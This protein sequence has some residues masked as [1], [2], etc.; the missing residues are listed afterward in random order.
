M[1]VVVINGSATAGKN[2]VVEMAGE[3]ADT[4]V[5]EISTIDKVIEAAN[6]L[7]Y[8]GI[9]DNKSRKFLSDLKDLATEYSNHSFNYV[10]DRVYRLRSKLKSEDRDSCVFFVHVREPDEIDKLKAHYKGKCVTLLIDRPFDSIPDNHADQD[11]KNYNYDYIIKNHFSPEEKGNKKAMKRLRQSVKLF[12]DII[13]VNDAAAFN[14]PIIF[15][16]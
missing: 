1:R 13:T 2:T 9:K 3:C 11:V 15:N 6:I 16:R 5:Y 12:M 8:S 7:G 4:L 14:T 10:L